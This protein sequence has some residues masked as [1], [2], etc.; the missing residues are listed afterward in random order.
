[1]CDPHTG[2]LQL[3][4]KQRTA[5]TSAGQCL[6]GVFFQPSVAPHPALPSSLQVQLCSLRGRKGQGL[7]R[8]QGRVPG[9][10]QGGMVSLFPIPRVAPDGV[11]VMLGENRQW[12]LLSWINRGAQVV[13]LKET[14]SSQRFFL[15]QIWG[16]VIKKHNN[17]IWNLPW[18]SPSPSLQPWM[19]LHGQFQCNW[20]KKKARQTAICP[21]AL[22]SSQV[23]QRDSDRSSKIFRRGTRQQSWGHSSALPLAPCSKD[24]PGKGLSLSIPGCS[25]GQ[26][27]KLVFK[28]FSWRHKGLL[29]SLMPPFNTELFHILSQLHFYSEWQGTFPLGKLEKCCFFFFPFL[30]FQLASIFHPKR[31]AGGGSSAGRGQRSAEINSQPSSG[32]EGW[33]RGA[34]RKGGEHAAH[35]WAGQWETLIPSCQRWWVDDEAMWGPGPAKPRGPNRWGITGSV[36]QQKQMRSFPPQEYHSELTNSGEHQNKLSLTVTENPVT[37]TAP[38]QPLSSLLVLQWYTHFGEKEQK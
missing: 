14:N 16:Q 21:G 8:E 29:T 17:Y 35:P 4:N 36:T 12:L 32:N 9:L 11:L 30:P 31:Q 22:N 3:H 25:L 33:W 38:S 7:P 6:G 15:N 24:L 18:N 1:M 28:W 5:T 20:K 27:R 10:A 23:T 13:Y 37:P 19:F 2:H 26:Q 34:Q